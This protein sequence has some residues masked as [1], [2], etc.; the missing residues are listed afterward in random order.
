MQWAGGERST[1]RVRANGRLATGIRLP[2]SI[3]GCNGLSGTVD[4]FIGVHGGAATGQAGVTL[5][6][7][8]ANEQAA[9]T[10]AATGCAGGAARVTASRT[11]G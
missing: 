5:K 2:R 6:L 8:F 9:G 11:G 1:F 7:R 10:L 3:A 4:V